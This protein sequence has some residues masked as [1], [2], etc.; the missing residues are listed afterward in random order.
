MTA[1][2]RELAARVLAAGVLRVLLRQLGK[3]GAASEL[4]V[5]LVRLGLALF[6]VDLPV[7]ALLGDQD[8]PDVAGFGRSVLTLILRVRREHLL[9]RDLDVLRDLVEQLLRQNRGLQP[10]PAPVS[11]CQ[12][13]L[14]QRPLVL[15]KLAVEL[16]LHELV[17]GL[18]EILVR[19]FD[20]EIVGRLSELLALDEDRHVLRLETLVLLCAGL[21]ELPLVRL[22]A[23]LREVDELV[24]LFLRDLGAVNDGHEA[25][26][27]G[28]VA[29]ARGR[30]ESGSR[31]EDGKCDSHEVHRS[32]SVIAEGVL[33][34]R[35]GLLEN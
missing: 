28:G 17:L 33:G 25:R 18:V 26:G 8:V 21:R 12:A 10:Q 35:C 4:G 27:D 2:D 30:D 11:R 22:V 5:D 13:L 9:I 3:V 1:R 15:G 34:R 20:T 7:C 19:D 31:P 6:E 29:A 23:V 16:G 24:E 14:L 32:P